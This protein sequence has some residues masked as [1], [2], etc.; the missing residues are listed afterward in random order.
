MSE[1]ITRLQKIATQLRRDVV[2]TVYYAGDGHP[3]PSLSITDILT[4]LYFDIMRINPEEP[5]WM[6]RDRFILS[7]G[8]ACPMLYAALARRGYF[9]PAELKTLRSLGSRLQ[10]HPVMHYTPGVDATSGSLGHGLPQGC[11]MALAAR[12]R[13]YDNLVF[14]LTGDGEQN[15][16]LVWEAAMSI[17]KFKLSNVIAMVDNNGVQSGGK[18]ET[19][20]GLVNLK[21]KWE[22]FGWYVIEIDGHK[23][24]EIVSVLEN[25]AKRGRTPI[26]FQQGMKISNEMKSPE[27]GQ[28]VMIIAHTLKGSG[29]PYMEGNN[30]WHKRVPTDEEHQLAMSILGGKDLE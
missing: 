1:R 19:I 8:H 16:G 17:A 27:P 20:G 12:R 24:E 14:V 4:V 28:P 9:P 2:N 21:E 15:E 11:G 23:L 3:G 13:G 22:A 26:D 5:D 25:A 18:V 10:G 7:K 6:Q 30:A 29:I